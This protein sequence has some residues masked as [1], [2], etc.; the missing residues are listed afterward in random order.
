MDWQNLSLGIAGIIISIVTFIVGYKQTIGARQARASAADSTITD[1]LL[2][3]LV[4]EEYTLSVEDVESVIDGKAAELRV[5]ASA[6]RP[7]DQLADLLYV[8][9][10]ESDLVSRDDRQRSL[11]AIGRLQKE[12][13]QR[14]SATIQDSRKPTKS[15][16]LFIVLLALAASILGVGSVVV[17]SDGQGA[18]PYSLGAQFT[19]AFVLAL[20]GAAAVTFRST[21]LIGRE[22][23][24]N[25]PIVR[26]YSAYPEA[27]EGKLA[28]AELGSLSPF[29]VRNLYQ[30][31]RDEEVSIQRGV[32]VGL[33]G[34]PECNLGLQELLDRRLVERLRDEKGKDVKN[35][36]GIYGLTL[37]G[38]ALARL[39][40]VLNVPG[41]SDVPPPLYLQKYVKSEPKESGQ[42]ADVDSGSVPTLPGSV[43]DSLSS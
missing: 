6:L 23:R 9:V 35:G 20:I 34:N 16:L 31:G 7:T 21:G 27:P 15:R 4:I 12:L 18:G 2:R 39:L 43:I 19:L 40:V 22:R 37:G 25:G 26:D 42:C 32:D 11:S 3:R 29:S 36:S 17:V 5:P 28:L 8:R 1:V 33:A 41:Q 38:R 13:A 30:L 24:I 14:T 10:L